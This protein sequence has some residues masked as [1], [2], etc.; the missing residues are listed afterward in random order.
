MSVT[1]T[2]ITDQWQYEVNGHLVYKDS[3]WTCKDDLSSELTAFRNYQKLVINNKAFK[4][5]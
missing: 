2:P 3:N 5:K 4:K 1:I